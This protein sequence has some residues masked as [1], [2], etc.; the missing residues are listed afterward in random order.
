[1]STRLDASRRENRELRQEL[2]DAHIA[3]P[4]IPAVLLS[5]I[6]ELALEVSHPT[7]TDDGVRI[8]R[9]E[10]E[11]HGHPTNRRAAAELKR[12][13]AVLY[14]EGARLCGDGFAIGE[15][16]GIVHGRRQPTDL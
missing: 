7:R 15:L 8:R 11:R 9:T 2:R 16:D 13:Q 14:R 5:G 6:A 10:T 3:L 12:V 4:Y 1:V